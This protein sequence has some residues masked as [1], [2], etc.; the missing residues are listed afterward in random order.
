MC[1]V[2]TGYHGTCEIEHGLCACTVDSPHAKARGLSLRTGAQTMLYL[3]PVQKYSWSVGCFGLNGTLRQYFSLIR[4]VSQRE[5]ERG[6]KKRSDR[7]EKKM[8]KQPPSAPTASA[9]GP[10]PTLIQISMTPRHW[11]FTQHHRTIRPPLQ[12]YSVMKHQQQYCESYSS[13]CVVVF[14]NVVRAHICLYVNGRSF[15]GN[16]PVIFILPPSQVGI[17]S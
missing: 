7:R 10:G 14:G 3:S 2:Y 17:P 16:N 12:K 13:H 5:R 1:K 11:K 6:R 9:V 8:S 4:A 15:S